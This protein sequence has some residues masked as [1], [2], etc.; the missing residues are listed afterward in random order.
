MTK[1]TSKNLKILI[2]FFN[3]SQKNLNLYR[4]K[5]PQ[6]NFKNQAKVE[7]LGKRD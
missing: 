5:V 1:G 3:S 4:M 6:S 7:L 2:G